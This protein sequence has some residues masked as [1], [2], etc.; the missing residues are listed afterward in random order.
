MA[1][2]RHD[3]L[4]PRPRLVGL[5]DEARPQPVR[6]EPLE[7]RHRQPRRRG[8]PAQDLPHGIGVQPRARHM[9]PAV[10][11]AEYRPAAAAAG[12]QPGF[13]RPDRAG[14]APRAARQADPG[15][16]AFRVTLAA[17]DQQPQAAALQHQVLA[18][19]RHQLGPAQRRGIAEQQQGAVAQAGEVARAGGDQATQLGGAEGGGTPRRRGSGLAQ[20]AAQ[21]GA[22]RGLPGRRR[23]AGH[24]VTAADGRQPTAQR[25]PAEQAGMVGEIGGHRF[26]RGGQRRKAGASA[27][28]L[29]MRPVGAVGALGGR[30]QRGAGKAVRGAERGEAGGGGGHRRGG[31][32]RGGRGE[33][34]RVGGHSA[35]D[36]GGLGPAIKAE[37]QHTR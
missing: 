26:R 30:R 28:G 37:L 36:P 10:D 7:R 17:R 14:L 20:Q 24:P 8:A 19:D 33:R 3:L 31:R 22:H 6:R 35:G 15:P 11:A 29:E 1:G 9:A 12:L 27:P 2:M 23:M 21:R 13:Q 5:G 32:R 4:V 34:R 25:G 18:L 16:L